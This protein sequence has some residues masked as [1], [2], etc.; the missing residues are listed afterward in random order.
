MAPGSV[1]LT[2]RVR[3]VCSGTWIFDGP[4]ALEDCHHAERDDYIAAGLRTT[5]AQGTRISLPDGAQSV[6]GC[7]AESR[8]ERGLPWI[9]NLS[10]R[11]RRPAI[12]PRRSRRLPKACSRASGTSACSA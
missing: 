2:L 7:S 10:V 12:S 6:G 4:A 5:P 9:F 8:R 11:F 3:I 1:V